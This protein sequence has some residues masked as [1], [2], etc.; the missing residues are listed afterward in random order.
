MSWLMRRSSWTL[1]Y[2]KLHSVGWV[3][4]H[5][6]LGNPTIELGSET[7][8]APNMSADQVAVQEF[9]RT[10]ASSGPSTADEV[11]QTH[12]ALI[13]LHKTEA[14]KIKRAVRYDYLDTTT[15]DLRERLLRR[16]L[17]LNTAGAPG[18]YRDVVAVTRERDGTLALG[19]AGVPIEWVLRMERFPATAELSTMAERG[20][21][22]AALADTLGREVSRYH[23]NAPRREA[24]GAILIEE[25]IDELWRVFVGMEKELGA[26]QTRRFIEASHAAHHCLGKLLNDRTQA[27][28]VRR[29]HGDL[30]LR[31]FVMWQG[32]PTPFDAL[33]FDERLGTCD[34]LYDLAFLLIDLSHRSLNRIA[35]GVFDSYMAAA[36]AESHLAALAALPLF[37]AIRSAILAM[38]EVQTARFRDDPGPLIRD[39]SRYLAEAIEHLKPRPVFLVAIGGLSGSGKTTVANLMAPGLGAYPGALHLSSDRERKAQFGVAPET[40]LPADAYRPRVSQRVYDALRQK[41]RLA[42]HAGHS[43]ILDAV[44]NAA[45]DRRLAEQVATDIGCRFLGLWLEADTDVR[46][47]RLDQRRPGASDADAEIARRQASLDTGEIKWTRLGT[48]ASPGDTVAMALKALALPAA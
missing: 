22:D 2:A 42:L 41:A 24:L 18:L 44:H 45:E 29:C 48:S 12:A 10:H 3:S 21:I 16:E 34:V 32:L 38:V 1:G 5:S 6:P 15:L 11:V 47:A 13:F 8:K 33:E 28:W 30:H 14:L 23:A 26:D 46:I 17:E 27:G 9:L 4:D 43:V 31:N 20:Q 40:H 39:A 35:H 36:R 37:A 25:I 19:G 7:R